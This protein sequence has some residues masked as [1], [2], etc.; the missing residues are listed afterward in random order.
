ME[1][2]C[3]RAF[4]SHKACMDRFVAVA[5]KLWRAIGVR[6]MFEMLRDLSKGLCITYSNAEIDKNGASLEKTTFIKTYPRIHFLWTDLRYKSAS[7]NLII[8]SGND[9][10]YRLELAYR[11]STNAVVL[12][13]LLAFLWKEGNY[14]KLQ[15]GEF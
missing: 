12:E 2:E 4:N 14:A 10:D 15:R 3:G 1:I 9:S 5:D 11:D 7:G 13:Q 6:L 8:Y